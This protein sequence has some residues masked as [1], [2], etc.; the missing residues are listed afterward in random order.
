MAEDDA[1]I[2]TAEPFAA[3]GLTEIGNGG[4]NVMPAGTPETFTDTGDE[5]PNTGTAMTLM[6]VD[7]PGATDVFAGVVEIWKLLLG[8]GGGEF[9][10][11][12]LPPQAARV[13]THKSATNRARKGENR[14]GVMRYLSRQKLCQPVP[15]QSTSGA[16]M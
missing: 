13:S 10:A 2:V 7:W 12:E 9:D 3:E 8:G 15:V 5:K 4:E 1:L 6:V 11:D 16:G 14:A